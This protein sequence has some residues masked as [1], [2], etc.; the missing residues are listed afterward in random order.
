MFLQNHPLARGDAMREHAGP[1]CFPQLQEEARLRANR[2][3]VE[4]EA[5]AE[6]GDARA[7]V[8]QLRDGWLCC[9][10]CGKWR[11]VE[12]ASLP[13]LREEEYAEPLP[14]ETFDWGAW[15]DQAGAR[16]AAFEARQ[17][18]DGAA[19][20]EM[21]D[22]DSEDSGGEGQ[23]G[24]D[25]ESEVSRASTFGGESEGDRPQR[26]EFE[27]ALRKLG[28]KS[29]WLEE[30]KRQELERL[31]AQE[32]GEEV[33]GQARFKPLFVCPMLM[34]HAPE[35]VAAGGLA[36]QTMSCADPDDF[37]AL[38]STRWPVEEFDHR[39]VVCVWDPDAES[40]PVNGEAFVRFG[41]M[42]HAAEAAGA[43]AAGEDAGAPDLG[44][45]KRH[46]R[47]P[48]RFVQAQDSDRLLM[49]LFAEP[50]R[51]CRRLPV[52]GWQR[53]GAGER[54]QKIAQP[55]H[56][57]KQHNLRR[58]PQRCL[59]L[60]VAVVPI[61][62]APLRVAKYFVRLRE[63]SLRAVHAVH[64]MLTRMVLFDCNCCRER[65]PAFHPA[66][67]PPAVVAEQMELLKCGAD[68]VAPCSNA[69]A[70]WEDL[71]LPPAAPEEHLLVAESCTGV[72][73]A[74]HA[75]IQKQR[76]DL[77]A[78]LPTLSA[79]ER[80]GRVVP[81]RSYRNH[82]DPLFMFPG[83]EVKQL[84]DSATVVEAMLVALEHMQISFVTAKSTGLTKFQKNVISFPQDIEAFASR[85]GW[86]GNF[87]AGDR[88]DSIRGPGADLERPVRLARGA[89][90]DARF[91]T[92]GD[93]H[94][95]FPATV[96]EVLDRNLVLDY[97][98]GGE[99]LE[100]RE[101]V[102]ARMTMPW[103]PKMLKNQ[104]VIML[105]R[106]LGR[107]RV[108][109]GLEVRWTLV[110]N[111]LRALTGPWGSDGRWL[112]GRF[113]LDG[114]PGSMHKYYDPRRFDMLS[115]EDIKREFAPQAGG[116]PEDLRT[117]E[118]LAAA[119]FEVRFLGDEDDGAEEE[120]PAEEGS[121]DERI[122]ERWL[123]VS[124]MQLGRV[125]GKWWWEVL[126]DAEDA[127]EGLKVMEEETAVDLFARIV[128]DVTAAGGG[129]LTVRSLCEWLLRHV[130]AAFSLDG[131]QRLEVLVDQ[132]VLELG[133]LAAFRDMEAPTA[134]MDDAQGQGGDPEEESLRLAETL[135]YGY[136]SR[137]DEPTLPR[138]AGR[139]CKA[140][141]LEY[142][143]GVA[144]LYEDPP[145]THDV[146]P[147]EYVQH[148]L[149]LASGHFVQGL[150]GH[151][152]V[153]ALVNHEL[154]SEA[155]GK[156][157]V[158]HRMAMRRQGVRVVGDAVLTRR[159]LREM[160]E[161]EGTARSL[162][163]Q[164]MAVG[165]D[166]R[167]TP[168]DWAW[169]AKTTRASVHHMSW[170]PPWVEP[171]AGESA[172][173]ASVFV[174]EQYRVEDRVGLGRTPMSWFTLNC[175]YNAAY[176]LHRLNVAASVAPDTQVP[177]FDVRREG[178]SGREH[179][180]ERFAFIRDSPDLATYMVS[181]RTE[182]MMR[183]LM[184]TLVP[185]SAAKPFLVMGRFEVGPGGN[186]HVHGFTA[187]DGNP[188][189]LR[190][191]ADVEGVG[192]L[193]PA[194]D[195]E[196]GGEDGQS[197]RSEE[198]SA[199][200]SAEGREE[201]CGGDAAFG[202]GG[203]VPADVPAPAETVAGGPVAV[204]AA[205]SAPAVAVATRMPVGGLLREGRAA[206]QLPWN[207]GERHAGEQSQKAMEEV[208]GV[209]FDRLVS[210]WNPC[211]DAQGN[212]RFHWDAELG[213][214]D[215]EVCLD[216]REP[217]STRLR[218][219]LD[220]VYRQAEERGDRAVDLAPVRRLV[221]ALVETSGRHKL[222]GMD[223]PKFGVH[224]CAAGSVDCPH[225]RYGY[226]HD[227]VPRCRRRKMR[228]VKGDREGSWFARFP[229]NDRLA[230]SF[231]EHLLL[232]NLGNVDWRPCL[233]LW[234]VVEYITKY[235]TKAPKGSRRLGE[236]LKDAVEEVCKYT[237]EGE[238]G[239]LLRK[240]L[241]KVYARTLGGR[242]FHLFEA[243]QLGLRLPLVFPFLDVVTLNVM[244]P[245]R[246]KNKAEVRRELDRGVNPEEMEM[247]WDS[248]VDNF[249]KR[250]RLLRRM[251]RGS[252]SIE[253]GEVRYVSLFE[254]YWKFLVS[255]G[256]IC[257]SFKP[258]CLMV[259]PSFG[260]DCA[261]VAHER[262][263][264]YARVC[265]LA[266]WRHMPTA[267][268]HAMLRRA[269]L[270]DLAV[271]VVD[272]RCW[273]ASEFVEQPPNAANPTLDKFLGVRDLWSKF[274]DKKDR[275]GRQVGWAL[276]LMEM[277]LDPLLVAWVPGWVVE[278]YE[279]W[280]PYFRGTVRWALRRY[281][282]EDSGN[283][284][285][286]WIVRG[287]MQRRQERRAAK[288]A[289][290]KAA[291]EAV[292]PPEEIGSG[293]EGGGDAPSDDDPGHAVAALG[294]EA[295]ARVEMEHEPVPG[296]H[297]MAGGLE[298]DAW[299]QAGPA[300]QLSAA[301]RAAAAADVVVGGAAGA[302]AARAVAPGDE[303][304]NPRGW[305]WRSAVPEGD[306]RRLEGLWV[307]W[308]GSAV[309]QEDEAEEERKPL[310]EYQEFAARIVEERARQ[311]LACEGQGLGPALRAY[312]PLR[313]IVTGSAGMGKSR[314]VRTSV[315]RVKRAVARVR[316]PAK[317]A[318]SCVLGAP[319]GSAAFQIRGGAST[320]HRNFGIPIGYCGPFH[321]K[322]EAYKRVAKKLKHA[323]LAVM[324]EM[325]MIGRSFLGKILDRVGTV[326]AADVS[327]DFGRGREVS[328]GGLD[329]MLTG[330]CAQIKGV[331][332]EY[333][334]KAGAYSGKAQNLGPGGV[335]PDG[336]KTPGEFVDMSR[337]F[338]NE[339]DDAVIL[340]RLQRLDEDGDAAYKAEAARWRDVT[341]RMADL[342][343]TP[344]D[345]DWL[346]QRNVS[347]LRATA[348]GREE[349][350]RFR[351]ATVLMDGRVRRG[352]KED[353]AD[354]WN[355]RE[356]R[357]HAARMKLP[358]LRMGAHHSK[359]KDAIGLEPAALDDEEF[360]GL[361]SS[362]ELCE[363][364]LVLLTK[365]LWV[366][367]G[368]MNGARGRVKGFMWPEGGDPRS[369]D[370]RL[371]APIC[372]LVEFDEV[373]W[374]TVEGEAGA[375]SRFSFFPK[376]PE[377]RNWVPIF[378][379]SAA[380]K[381]EDSVV[382]RQF[383]LTLA[384]ALMTLTRAR[385]SLGKKI[386][387]VPGVGLVAVTRVRHYRHVVF[388][389]DLPEWSAFQ[390]ARHKEDYR[391]RRR[392]ELRLQAKFS[393]TLRKYGF[394]SGQEWTREE[395]AA[396]E[397]LLR[398]LEVVGRQRRERWRAEGRLARKQGWMGADVCLWSGE[399]WRRE[400]PRAVLELAGGDAARLGFLDS[401]A[402]RLR[403]PL[404]E[405]AV[406]EAL[407]CLI[408]EWL[409]P[410][411]D[412]KKPKGKTA[413]EVENV[414]VP[415]VADGFRVDVQRQCDLLEPARTIR[416]D[417]LEFFLRLVRHVCQRL[418]LPVDVG[419]SALGVRVGSAETVAHLCDTV[420]GWSSWREGGRWRA[421]AAQ[422]FL[423][424][425]LW[426]TEGRGSWN[427]VLV[428]LLG[429]AEGRRLSDGGVRVQVQDRV[430]R[431]KNR[432]L[433]TIGR[434]AAALLGGAEA[435]SAGSTDV[436]FTVGPGCER[437]QD[438]ILLVLGLLLGRV[439][440][441]AQVPAMDSRAPSF[442]RDVRLALA[443]VFWSVREEADAR[444]SREVLPQFETEA[445]CRE[446]LRR[447]V[448][449]P[450][451]GVPTIPV[452]APVSGRKA[453]AVK[454]GALRVLTWNISAAPGQRNTSA[455]A[456]DRWSGQ[457]NL[458]RQE[459]EVERLQPDLVALQECPSAVALA[460][461]AAKYTLLGA[462][463]AHAGFVH[464]Y[465][466]K[467]VEQVREDV[468][469]GRGVP[470]VVGQVL[471]GGMRLGVVAMHL[472]WGAGAAARRAEQLRKLVQAVPAACQA[473]L[474]MGDANVRGEEVPGWCEAHALVEAPFEKASW[475]PSV[476]RFHPEVDRGQPGFQ[477]DRVLCRGCA[478]ASVYM[479]GQCR[480][481]EDGAEF[482][483]SDHFGLLGLVD[484]HEAYSGTAGTAAPRERRK[485][486]GRQRDEEALVEQRWVLERQRLGRQEA[487]LMRARASDRDRAELR[488]RAVKL[489]KEANRRRERE[490]A[491]VFG[492]ESLFGA[493]MDAVFAVGAAAP[494]AP[495]AVGIEM[496]LGLSGAGW[497]AQAGAW[498]PALGGLRNPGNACYAN[499][500]CQV[501]LRLPAVA[502]WL[503]A[504]GSHCQGQRCAACRLRAS[505][506]QVGAGCTADIV[507]L[508]GLAGARF[509]DSRQHDAGEFLTGLLGEMRSR[510]LG[511]D[512]SGPWPG[513]E[514]GVPMATHVDRVFGYVEEQRL[515][516][517][518]C[519]AGRRVFSAGTVLSLPLPEREDVSCSVNDL[520]CRYAAGE[521][522]SAE[523]AG[524]GNVVTT[525]RVQ[526]RMC[527]RP[528]VLVMQVRR[529]QAGEAAAWRH[530]VT[531][532][533]QLSLPGVGDFELAGVVYH[534]GRSTEAGHNWSIGRGPDGRFWE[535]DDEGCQRMDIE[536]A[537]I[538]PRSV[539]LLVYV[540]PSG[541]AVF[542]GMGDGA[543]AAA[544][545][546]AGE[547]PGGD[548]DVSLS[549]GGMTPRA[550]AS[551]P[552]AEEGAARP[553]ADKRGLKSPGTGVWVGGVG[554]SPPVGKSPEA[555]RSKGAATG[556]SPP[557]RSPV[558]KAARVAE[559][560]DAAEARAARELAGQRFPHVPPFSD[561]VPAAGASGGAS[562]PAVVTAGGEE[563]RAF[564]PAVDAAGCMAR[565]WAGG[566]GGQCANRR[567]PQQ[568]FCRQHR[569][570]QVHGR[571]D[572]PIPLEKLMKFRAQAQRRRGGEGGVPA[573]GGKGGG[574]QRAEV[575]VAP[576]RDG[577]AP[578]A[579]ERA[580]CSLQPEDRAQI[581]ENAGRV[582]SEHVGELRREGRAA[583]SEELMEWYMLRYYEDIVSDRLGLRTPEL[584]LELE[585]IVRR[586]IWGVLGSQ[587]SA[588]AAGAR[589]AAL[590][591]S[592]PR[593]ATGS[594]PAPVSPVIQEAV[595]PCV[596]GAEPDTWMEDL[597]VDAPPRAAAA[598]PGVGVSAQPGAAAAAAVGRAWTEDRRGIGDMDRV[599]AMRRRSQAADARADAE[600]RE[601]AGRRMG[602]GPGRGGAR[603]GAGGGAVHGRG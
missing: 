34:R 99:G 277:L 107:G 545:A 213:A 539:Y 18:Q 568:E 136:P 573:A 174:E 183:V 41:R 31:E 348:A 143:M 602:R 442:V 590:A 355:A 235:A 543:A 544:Q 105:R 504:H 478:Q 65:F 12:L 211:R 69:V 337:L 11:L 52:V 171:P 8:E 255:N 542:A 80:E 63:S 435:R 599:L 379:D 432:D 593:G 118:Q 190:V 311:R 561:F 159:H 399:E 571:V 230:C 226:P 480:F 553:H 525:H 406:R 555:K 290:A 23:A 413:A 530:G 321:S 162:V 20:T 565:I 197:E 191:R 306:Q 59:P 428:S 363:E 93:G 3:L 45:P 25:A 500:V 39:D 280:N 441:H 29:R 436:E 98:G 381:T 523:C 471:V 394:C 250:L 453:P 408:P 49:S 96:R 17:P 130:G 403:E 592:G 264:D 259:T 21:E 490:R 424:P 298:D 289:A 369:T 586:A 409:D 121:V 467:G 488:A 155:G 493:A 113:R 196:A 356:L 148:M 430:A 470:G 251:Q 36:W 207:L 458:E 343:W 580:G 133:T 266:Y 463:E 261:N 68:G 153:W 558:R 188:R 160:V 376:D 585:D 328:M 132:V 551:A 331:C 94:L 563:W 276:A 354:V 157:H 176:D 335:R 560:M 123:E 541:A 596:Q 455:Q 129:A 299:A 540:R 426:D 224:A 120:R 37:Q 5:A 2:P 317:A 278:Q 42:L 64:A 312:R 223:P 595:V 205:A 252:R 508:R 173:A 531:A 186:P 383:P 559:V 584:L 468:R 572:G 452:A 576:P 600:R 287:E 53:T 603:G 371:R 119:G 444:G 566:R 263:E 550:A 344:E 334:W 342:E 265:V 227:R 54:W 319:T 138:A 66:F 485:A 439:A 393:R 324:D 386:A 13:A 391:G 258:V 380:S 9:A 24:R 131:E 175:K 288:D 154:L 524:C 51:G 492:A 330:H 116:Q 242:D 577:G 516:C 536:V 165:R 505:G 209:F 222:H 22:E 382:R 359:P 215:V 73:Q 326:K 6:E 4:G 537:R 414:G 465:A 398:K 279:R 158:V 168:M 482:F 472:A 87:Q 35:G 364:A 172:D 44:G 206:P 373:T 320:L 365:N 509:R 268:R 192:D 362:L 346:A 110:S 405:P 295:A 74:C 267:E 202:A 84:F 145:R 575:E 515:R 503:E 421:R 445:A 333:L 390:E 392:F 341:A 570:E 546:G 323:I 272:E 582:L 518:G 340:Q 38:K 513:V 256:R 366:E 420:E 135:V 104:L 126:V 83:G 474:V 217:E 30:W 193:A 512:R 309:E 466:R 454:E 181:L 203:G 338:L 476:N 384:W 274:M 137:Y 591:G 396:A 477:F 170:R 416:K 315:R 60:E 194:S 128:E 375:T 431:Y 459:L 293:E 262:H 567:A 271:E 218:P 147:P 456:P 156:G 404:H 67:G 374:P 552:G 32:R 462:V 109:E 141:P 327:S 528:N 50:S 253:E 594:A 46:R 587:G 501:L 368:L 286:L 402:E 578:E 55:R 520:Y 447:L 547:V 189:L 257:R 241:Q 345:R 502:R 294:E 111:I 410:R 234:A 535:F 538:H 229:C 270:E 19:R 446:L 437:A 583:T 142:P 125:V 499:S 360:R 237:P 549:F 507:R 451:P 388:E 114:A 89:P 300:E 387:S 296:D 58:E 10:R 349:L 574:G 122:F 33:C 484:V 179:A 47:Q 95:V 517:A 248:K 97:D 282:P 238:G 460:R 75:D 357:S 112:G 233:N 589:G 169:K 216:Q 62:Q 85:L 61:K 308:G 48:S 187:G 556:A 260:A 318:A 7:G 16:W 506:A 429:S 146:S 548:G 579:P 412:G 115:E 497:G 212:L 70:T 201:M 243:M 149:R 522:V 449:R 231:E 240:S 314:T 425:V 473:L 588:G 532:D 407:G 372:V 489:A 92:D 495:S 303:L 378:R 423:L 245:R 72:C 304:V 461:L 180:R 254:F 1:Q 43:A 246:V 77:A 417:V 433:Q 581:A 225:C 422:E 450:E 533:E 81:R 204:A 411:E 557:V 182:L 486:L 198:G 228:L 534:R 322:S 440:H 415:L 350:E 283:R 103:H 479:V 427:W 177:V 400:L 214:H 86:L 526:R 389:Q 124:S 521:E 361:V 195:S 232:C 134:G 301:G 305:V 247:E 102:T 88:V 352:E 385:V 140:F 339:F 79:E 150:R 127:P 199:Q 249:D 316:G 481:F 90:E 221:A 101:W 117:A 56:L 239:D 457:E 302:A 514:I 244:G 448:T 494:Q 310:D 236:V 351:D 554:E 40:P 71:P 273:G 370:S 151:R 564:T 108:L 353:V 562:G 15:L 166:V 269:M 100:R 475:N 377:K 419:T 78:G 464:L 434:K 397:E 519:G 498:S 152:V 297:P 510:E 487:A 219:L 511:G 291:G 358:V 82:M 144:D 57:G 496:L 208:F 325:S 27:K 184:P 26:E 529:T 185:H 284:R 275:R 28:S 347:A 161:N 395:A 76:R 164:L 598:G 106:N 292:A 438:S 307:E 167:S 313:L 367:A 483:L 443:Q 200:G 285:L 401:V 527:T 418:R 491:Q 91:A 178:W 469:P 336:A 569:G 332:E 281:A 139:F 14:G 329:V 220:A 210:E 601:L 597:E 163:N